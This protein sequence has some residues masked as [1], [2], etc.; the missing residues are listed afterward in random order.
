MFRIAYFN[1]LYLPSF[2]RLHCGYLK[3]EGSSLKVPPKGILIP[4]KGV[5]FPT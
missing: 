1:S 2:I 4:L 3:K 5:L